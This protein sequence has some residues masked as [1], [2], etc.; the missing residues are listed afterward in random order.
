MAASYSDILGWLNSG[1]NSENTHMIVV[2]D[3]FDYE[4]YPVYVGKN[5]D[6]R[7]IYNKY[8]GKN[9]Q[10]VMEVYSYSLP[11]DEQMKERRA[12]HFE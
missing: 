7:E 9:M 8:N 11:L 10:R 3:D 4:D 1:K 2:C 5:E 6:V 12:F